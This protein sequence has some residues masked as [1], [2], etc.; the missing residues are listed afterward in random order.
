[1]ATTRLSRNNVHT[2]QIKATDF[3]VIHFFDEKA[4][5]KDGELG[6][7]IILIYSLG[8]DGV[9]REFSNGKWVP[10]PITL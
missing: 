7:E 8:E 4:K 9:I 10:F 3:K 2:T 1:M 5:R 6:G